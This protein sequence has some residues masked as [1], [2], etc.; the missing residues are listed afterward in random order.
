MLTYL[1]KCI[2]FKGDEQTRTNRTSLKSVIAS[3][4]PEET[5]TETS[6]HPLASQRHLPSYIQMK[7]NCH[8]YSV[9]TIYGGRVTIVA[10][11]REQAIRQFNR[12]FPHE[13]IV[14]VTFVY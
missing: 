3:T 1:S 11:S 12:A 13:K 5:T 8:T 2:I 7:V 4:S 14:G 10:E 9:C 6:N